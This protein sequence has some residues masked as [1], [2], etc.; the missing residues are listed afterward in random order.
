MLIGC[1][2]EATGEDQGFTVVCGWVTHDRRWAEF[3]TDWRLLL[4]SYGV[5]CLHTLEMLK[6]QGPYAVWRDV[7]GK[8]SRFMS[9]A[10]AIIRSKVLWGFIFFVKHSAFTFANTLYDLTPL[11]HN[12]YALAARSCM[13]MVERWRAQTLA[14][15]PIEFIFDD[16]HPARNALTQ[17]TRALPPFLPE[18]FFEPSRDLPPNERW[19][20]GRTGVTQLQAADYLAYQC[21]KAMLERTRIGSM[22]HRQSLQA[23]IQ[24]RF[25]MAGICSNKMMCRFCSEK[26]IKR[27]VPAKPVTYAP[28]GQGL[29]TPQI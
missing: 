4:L 20:A 18:P 15:E 16:L 7:P 22:R 11:L 29:S 23:T 3:E 5:P 27:K 19:P 14:S 13:E 6:F 9:D 24:T 28:L 10:A 25:H 17:A 21:R 12:P 26:N 1:F 8:Q 2:H